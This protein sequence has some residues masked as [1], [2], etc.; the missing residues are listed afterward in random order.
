[1]KN[2]VIAL[3]VLSGMAACGQALTFSNSI[4]YQ[5]ISNATVN[6]AGSVIGTA[7]VSGTGIYARIQ[8]GGL[9]TTNA[10]SGQFQI[11]LDGTNWTSVQ[12]YTPTATNAVIAS[13]PISVSQF[14]V[15]GRVQLTTTNAVQAGADIVLVP[16]L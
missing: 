4:V 10:L 1:M 12:A 7:K 9:V 2:F 13:Q 5:T 8:N 11:S 16:F 15:Y 3:M 14:T 6:G